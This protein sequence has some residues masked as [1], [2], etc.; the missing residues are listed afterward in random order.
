MPLQIKEDEAITAQCVIQDFTC[1]LTSTRLIIITSTKEES[2]PLE[3]IAAIGVYE[4]VERSSRNTVRTRI[5]RVLLGA[6]CGF[7]FGALLGVCFMS[8]KPDASIYLMVVFTTVGIPFSLIMPLKENKELV[9]RIIFK[10][11]PAKQY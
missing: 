2:Y 3:E 5:R 7:L 1:I 6:G 4:D 10:L 8:T 11:S 9:L